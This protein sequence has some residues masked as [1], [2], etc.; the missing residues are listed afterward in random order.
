MA[1]LIQKAYSVTVYVA[2]DLATARASLRKQCIEEGLCVTL[3]AV[4]F[5][6]THG[7]ES[8]VRVGFVNYPRFP[9]TA[10]EIYERAKLVALR[11]RDDLCQRTALV[12]AP[13]KTEWLPL[14]EVKK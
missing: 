1:D 2:G 7:L 14:E 6:Y 11:L 5:V 13:D 8:G 3:Q 4:E 10:D 12:D 9:K